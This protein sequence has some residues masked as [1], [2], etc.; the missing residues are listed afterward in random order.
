MMK[1]WRNKFIEL[2]FPLD[3]K[4]IN[5]DE[6]E[7]IIEEN[8]PKSG[9]L[10]KYRS[11]TEKDIENLENDKIWVPKPDEFNDP[12]DCSLFIDS[13]ELLYIAGNEK[14]EI[15][16]IRKDINKY[17][18]L[19][20]GIKIPDIEQVIKEVGSVANKIIQ[21]E[22]NKLRDSLGIYCLTEDRDSILMWSH[23]AEN[24]K[25][26]CIEY[27]F[28]EIKEKFSDFYPVVY[29]EYFCEM[30]KYI[31]DNNA[32]IIIRSALSK[33]EQWNYEKEWRIILRNDI[34]SAGHL[35]DASKIKAIYLG[36]KIKEDYEDKLK[37]IG[38]SK[39]VPVYKMK[40]MKNKFKLDYFKL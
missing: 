18:K 12:Y 26:F 8:K 4:L 17:K 13:E 33:S 30:S 10:Y 16:D 29:S 22:I 40:M 2:K 3:K 21:P 11:G 25:G 9:K 34:K 19:F 38:E 6:A 39:G 27:D 24:H 23:Y 15:D 31:W 28:E 14:G 1:D 36:C 7:K 32:D 37:E 5:L 20:P 35:I